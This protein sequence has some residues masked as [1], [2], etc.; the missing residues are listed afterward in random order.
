MPNEPEFLDLVDSVEKRQGLP[1]GMLQRIVQ[2][3][4]HGI[5]PEARARILKE[6]G[7]DAKLNTRNALE[8]A[9]LLL[10][11]SLKNNKG[12]EALALAEY[13]SGGDRTG[14]DKDTAKFVRTARRTDMG[15]LMASTGAQE[16]IPAAPVEPPVDVATPAAA[17]EPEGV[18]MVPQGAL[19]AYANGSMKPEDMREMEADI[20]AGLV[21]VPDGFKIGKTEGPGLVDRA[22]DSVTGNMRRTPETDAAPDWSQIPEWEDLGTL[23]NVAA[24]LGSAKE[25]LQVLSANFPG[26]KVRQDEKG[27]LFAFSPKAGKEFAVKPGLDIGDVV[28]TAASIPIYA[29]GAASGVGIPAMIGREMAV[30][31]GI[32]V[33]QAASGGEFNPT[34]IAAAGLTAGVVPA[35][36]ALKGKAGQFANRALDAVPG[37]TTK[38][39]APAMADAATVVSQKVAPAAPAPSTDAIPM[40]KLGALVRDATGK[41]E[42]ATAARVEIARLASIDP[43]ADAAFKRLG[44][45]APIDLL[46]DNEQIKNVMGL[47]RSKIGTEA[48]AQFEG[49]IDSMV[50]RADD[51]MKEFG[52]ITV[53]GKPSQSGASS[54]V[55]DSLNAS[56]K[57][58]SAAESAAHNAIDEVVPKSTEVRVDA[59]RD[60]MDKRADDV[61]VGQLSPTEK[62]MMSFAKE[63]HPTYG[64]IKWAKSIV[65]KAI[66]GTLNDAFPGLDAADLKRLYGAIAQSQGDAVEQVGGKV[67]RDQLDAANKLSVAKFG[68]QD[69]IKGGFGKEGNGDL[70]G[71]MTRA[72]TAAKKDGSKP[73]TDLL[74][75]VPEALHKDVVS[76]ALA[77]AVSKG[78]RFSPESFVSFYEGLRT[79]DAAYSKIAG[80]LGPETRQALQDMYVFSKRMAQSKSKVKFTGIGNQKFESALAGDNLMFRLLETVPG[81]GIAAAVGGSV[82]SVAGPAGSMAGAAA[83][84]AG[85]EALLRQRQNVLPSIGKLFSSEEFIDLA[86]MANTTAP[87]SSVAD[88]SPKWKE[89][90]RRVALS[91]RWQDFAKA[92]NMPRELK[93]SERFI[94]A[95]LQASRQTKGEQ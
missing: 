91:N 12:D 92:A 63:P 29:A 61:G 6:N 68:V 54:R 59:L 62:Q 48:Q 95:A 13:R 60:F 33:A 2:M 42:K 86:R 65:G 58:L 1:P 46:S 38:Q 3:H 9:G 49:A 45:D 20:A 94:T 88:A 82:G 74:D 8:A 66:G 47:A 21:T 37:S 10:G 67:L 72:M 57:E 69:R 31:G 7:I 56:Q 52:A 78:G 75:V 5:P 76:T 28:R 53:D 90:V 79:N 85:V 87:P 44:M 15:T 51:R 27:N 18:L 32:E 89:A 70:A 50:S 14:W 77:S 83:T 84:V 11:S 93:A 71:Q 4:G 34:D 41:G 19:D 25:A 35:A 24:T 40:E 30:Q 64:G 39:A 22:I 43:E 80:I 55:L 36:A 17:G 16:A 73:L 81:K 26:V 23:K